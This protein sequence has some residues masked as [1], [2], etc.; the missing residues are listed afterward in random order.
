MTYAAVFVATLAFRPVFDARGL[1][2][3]GALAALCVLPAL[4]DALRPRAPAMSAEP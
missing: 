4:G 1:A 3:C 2:A